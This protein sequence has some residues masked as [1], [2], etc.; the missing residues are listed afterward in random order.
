MVDTEELSN[1]IKL[2]SSEWMRLHFRPSSNKS[3]ESVKPGEAKRFV[4]MLSSF[5]NPKPLP[6][7]KPS[8]SD[9]ME[10]SDAWFVNC[11]SFELALAPN[12]GV[13]REYGR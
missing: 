10:I 2:G 1:V 3:L 6:L 8:Q 11:Q 9:V 5:D 13:L 7:H 4:V 12:I